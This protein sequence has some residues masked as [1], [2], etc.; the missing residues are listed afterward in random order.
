MNIGAPTIE[1]TT[2]I[3]SSVGANNVLETK[4]ADIKNIPPMKSEYKFE[5]SEYGPLTILTI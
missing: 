5:T 4:S 1:V 3:G 2:P